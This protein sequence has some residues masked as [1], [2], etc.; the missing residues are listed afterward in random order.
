[1]NS[2]A[3]R[4]PTQKKISRYNR[5][6]DNYILNRLNDLE[7]EIADLWKTIENIKKRLIEL[8][9]SKIV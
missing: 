8:E 3:T 4:K 7:V 6:W 1:M 5:K 9:K 2:V